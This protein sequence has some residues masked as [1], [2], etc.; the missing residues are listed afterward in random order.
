MGLLE[1]V[2]KILEITLLV[3]WNVF[4]GYFDSPRNF[5]RI[6]RYQMS[7]NKIEIDSSE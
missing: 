5:L 2:L 6:L 1:N 7:K 4:L 3:L